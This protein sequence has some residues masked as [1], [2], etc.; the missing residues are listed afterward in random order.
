MHDELVDRLLIQPG[1]RLLDVATGTGEVAA[2]AARR[3]ADV[4][5]IDIAPGMLAIA[6]K[7][8]QDAGI[9]FDLGDVQAL[10]YGDAS[11]DIVTST[12]G[13][14]FAPD[15]DAVARELTRVCRD[16]LGLTVWK[17]NP[18]LRELYERFGLDSPEGGLPFQW[19]TDGYA[20]V[21]LAAFDLVVEDRTWILDLPDGAAHWEFWSNSAPPFK[22]MIS[23]LDDAARE[24]FRSAY[25]AYCEQFRKDGRVL[26]PRE[27]LMILG[28]KR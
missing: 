18:G 27:Y 12:F 11:Y 21:R 23:E 28:R 9:R 20:Q 19:G 2:R 7:T 24:E 6:E 22:A 14:I 4:T 8:H 1:E 3:G 5:A 10:P 16:R 26:V 13:M 25:V 17:P 15:H